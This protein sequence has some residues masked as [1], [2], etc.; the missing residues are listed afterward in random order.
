MKEAWAWLRTY[1]LDSFVK[2]QLLGR[3][4]TL[5][6]D[7]P[8][9]ARIEELDGCYVVITD[10]PADAASA[11]TIWDRYG[12]LQKVER[13]FRTLKTSLLELRPIFLRKARR[14][15]AHAL[16]AM[17]ALKLARRLER[18]V[19]PLGLTAQDALDRLTAVRL[20]SLADPALKLW[21]LPSHYHEPVQ[22]VLDVLPALPPPRLSRQ[23]DTS[24]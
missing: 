19:A 3:S 18:C 2:P 9:K 20:V 15:R 22:R 23:A 7:E 8:V 11:Q 12:D 1:K 5:V 10:V 4:V 6:V 16:V 21:R 13:D 24:I 17:L 14:T